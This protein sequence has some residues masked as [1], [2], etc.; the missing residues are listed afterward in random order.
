MEFVASSTAVVVVLVVVLAVMV[1]EI[2]MELDA[3]MLGLALAAHGAATVRL[4]IGG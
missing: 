2:M 4:R 3:S 1:V